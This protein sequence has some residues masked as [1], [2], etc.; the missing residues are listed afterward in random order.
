[1]VK[2]VILLRTDLGYSKGRLAAFAAHAS[3]K[4]FLDRAYSQDKSLLCIPIRNDEEYYWLTQQYTKI[5]LTID[6]LS[7]LMHYEEKAKSAGLPTAIHYEEGIT[8]VSLAIG[9]AEN[10]KI[11]NITRHL[12][13]LE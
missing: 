5:C 12:R 2:Q 11:D 8:P 4:V 9:P 1:M 7:S 13:L 10:D 6:S 3:L